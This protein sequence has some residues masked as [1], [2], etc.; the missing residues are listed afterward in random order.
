MRMSQAG[1]VG[2]QQALLVLVV[3]DDPAVLDGITALL[4]GLG[5]AALSALRSGDA[6]HLIASCPDIDVVLAD[7]GMP[8]IDG[9]ELARRVEE[10]RPGLPLILA[11]GYAGAVPVELGDLPFLRKPF[12]GETFAATLVRALATR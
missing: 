12:Q 10:V 4:E 9:V 6:L 2:E 3:D 7:L 11:T 5:H 1:R 8:E